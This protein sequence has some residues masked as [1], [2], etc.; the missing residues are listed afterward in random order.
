MREVSAASGRYSEPEEGKTT[1]G[2]G[3][4]PRCRSTRRLFFRAFMHPPLQ[5]YQSVCANGWRDVG[6]A[7]PYRKTAS[8]ITAVIPIAPR[9]SSQA[10]PVQNDRTIN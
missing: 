5:P 1:S 10:K 4:A 3:T 2:Q 6:D 7:V 8:L 9:D